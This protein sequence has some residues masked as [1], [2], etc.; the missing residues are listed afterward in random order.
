MGGERGGKE[1]LL[2]VMNCLSNCV[3]SQITED[4]VN[5]LNSVSVWPSDVLENRSSRYSIIIILITVLTTFI[6]CCAHLSMVKTFE[7]ITSNLVEQA[8]FTEDTIITEQVSLQIERVN[9]YRSMPRSHDNVMMNLADKF[10]LW[11][12]GIPTCTKRIHQ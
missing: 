10:K 2:V 1:N 6:F 8:N 9:S 12:K 7:T 3:M 11:R 5:V 4:T